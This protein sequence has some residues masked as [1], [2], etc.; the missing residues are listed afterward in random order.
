MDGYRAEW[1]S[2]GELS[3]QD[4]GLRLSLFNRSRDRFF[5]RLV[6]AK[7]V[8]INDF[9]IF[10]ASDGSRSVVIPGGNYTFNEA[11]VFLNTGTHR[12][13]SAN[14]SVWAGEFY[15]GDH[16]E[17]RSALTWR[18]SNQLEFGLTH[19]ENSIKLPG[20]DFKVRQINLQANFS[21]NTRWSWNNLVQYD[22]VSELMGLNSRLVYIPEAGQQAILVFNYG[23]QDRDKDN[24]FTS[25]NTDLSLRV[26]YTFRY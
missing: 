5:A 20:G 16:V 22:N 15:D 2:S 19:N 26:A 8:L 23:A 21:L 1:L 9:S 13:L 6:Q 11:R 7:E 14:L 10:R 17:F 4:I 18:P 3:S 12:K 25:T 24:N